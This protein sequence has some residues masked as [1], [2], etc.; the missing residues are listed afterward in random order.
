MFYIFL[1]IIKCDNKIKDETPR[2]PVLSSSFVLYFNRFCIHQNT[3]TLC[4]NTSYLLYRLF[5]VVTVN[6][7]IMKGNHME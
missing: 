5:H 2:T 7:D 1:N 3:R 4:K 6:M